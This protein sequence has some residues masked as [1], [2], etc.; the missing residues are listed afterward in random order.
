MQSRMTRRGF[1]QRVAMG[2]IAGVLGARGVGAL[3]QTPA[4]AVVRGPRAGIPQGVASGDVT[5]DSAVI[6][7][8]T[9]REARMVVEWDTS[10]AFRDVR[11][12]V[13]P[14]TGPAADFTAKV[15][16]E[17]LPSGRKVFYR[18]RFE[19]KQ[20]A[21]GDA[22][23]GSLWVP[24]SEAAPVRFAW[25]GDTCGQGW[26]IDESRGGMKTYE[27]IR[28]KEPQFFVHSGDTIYGDN[29]LKA[30]VPLADGTVW[31]NLVT[32][33]KSKV[34]ETLAEFRG[35]YRYSYLDR[36]V[37]GL[38]A[39]VPLMVQ[40]DDHEVLNN[41][42]PGQQLPPGGWYTERNVD[43][44]ASRSKQA[45]FEY[46]PIADHPDRR[47]YRKI[48]R[49]PLCDLFFL[50]LRSHRGPNSPNRQAVAGK[51]TELMGQTQVAWLAESLVASQAVWKFVCC[52]MPI[53]LLVRDTLGFDNGANGD[54]PALGRELEMAW[55]LKRLKDAGVRNVVW[56]T[57]DVHYC[58]SHHYH[59]SRASFTEFDPFW[60]FVSGPLNSGTF[61]PTPF[62]MTF[63]PELKYSCRQPGAPTSGPWTADQ[64]FGTVDIDPKTRA[65]R[66]THWNKNGERLWTG[67][68]EAV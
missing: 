23:Q 7:S 63:G 58:A 56:L 50:D 66:V 26:G 18:V 2:G 8:R 6:W 33:E 51:E 24:G 28:Q 59:P 30:E 13:G 64:Y 29:P 37:R 55:L 43:L 49:G 34:A 68:I 20:G 3:G 38:L 35:N 39:E 14:V 15:R 52:D 54:G 22:T 42:W 1:G 32:E 57:A 60:E 27:A 67:E 47:I 4:P 10:E 17:G 44:L 36:N 61:G 12:I 16:L 62:D 46:H 5:L 21:T 45:F 65:C 40:W 41:W 48:A 31:R 53:G 9:D 11:R 25:S 19:D